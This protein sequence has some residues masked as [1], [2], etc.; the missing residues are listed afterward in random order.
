M[1]P[2]EFWTALS[3]I[4]ICLSAL[5]TTFTLFFIARQLR[6]AHRAT[7]GTFIN[8]LDKELA[9]FANV[10]NGT[11][12]PDFANTF[13]NLSNVERAS[14][15]R[16]FDYFERVKTLLD[17]GVIDLHVVDR[18]IGYPFFLM[19]NNSTLQDNIILSTDLRFPQ[20]Y[21]L[22]AQLKARRIARHSF[23]PNL[24]TDLAVRNVKH[25]QACLAVYR[26]LL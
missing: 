24:Q 4:G 1:T 23:I 9:Q 13:A 15:Y 3:A 12:E 22:H 16:C 25:Y 19:V 21:A 26:R 5:A 7:Q 6:A 2:L 17:S 18:M 8:E 10:L 11:H 14:Y 20:L